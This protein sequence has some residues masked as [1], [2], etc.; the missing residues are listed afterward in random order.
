VGQRRP[1]GKTTLN[2]LEYL[3][4]LVV[5]AVVILLVIHPWAVYFTNGLPDHWDP[6][7]DA[8]HLCWNAHNILHGSV[9]RPVY[10]ANHFYPHAYT[11]AFSEPMW[12]PSFFAAI[13]YGITANPMLTWNATMLFFW[14]LS[15]VTMFALLRELAVSRA[16]AYLGA[17]IFCLMPYRLAYYVEINMSLCFAIPLTYLFLIRWL[18]RRAW[19]DAVLLGLSVWIAATTCLYYTLIM[20][21]PMPFVLIAYLV[22]T[23][24]ILGQGRTYATGATAVVLAALLCA[25]T[26]YPYVVLRAEGKYAR[27]IKQQAHSSIQPLTYLRPAKRSLVH[28]FAAKADP[29]ETV[30]FPG[31]TL[32]ALA[33][34][35]WVRR[36]ITFRPWR[37]APPRVKRR[38]VLAYLRA[39]LWFVFVVLA[40][41]GTYHTHTSSFAAVKDLVVPSINLVFWLSLILLFMPVDRDTAGTAPVLAGL[42]VGAVACFILSFGPTLTLGHMKDTIEVGGGIAARLHDLV[43][44]FS[45]VRVM[46]RFTIMIL[47][48]MIVAGCIALDGFLLKAPRRLRWMWILLFVL[49]LTETYSKPYEFRDCR[50]KLDTPVQTYIRG[51]ENTVSIAQIPYGLRDFDGEAMLATVGRWHY[52]ING[53]C[54]FEPKQHYTLKAYL[55]SDQSAA[56]DWLRQIWPPAYLL[57]DREGVYWWKE[58]KAATFTEDDLADDWALVIQDPRFAL[59]TLKPLDETPP[60]VVRRLRTDVLRRHPRLRFEARAIEVPQG[61]TA[62]VR[63]Q[64]NGHGVAVLALTSELQSF[65]ALVPRDATG[66]LFGEEVALTLQFASPDRVEQADRAGLWAVRNLDFFEQ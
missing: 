51:M 30:V 24:R 4:L 2:A 14:A 13:V 65:E 60:R 11:M 54:G 3:A 9:L 31:L 19:I 63:I 39:A 18:R 58:H 59:Y 64:V 22:R 40:V 17:A 45:I 15:G 27:S 12:P 56:A 66:S 26:M 28:R 46:T 6:P 42:G 50:D 7:T 38:Q 33:C 48:Y 36:R 41:Y 23:P 29:G 52:L 5:L 8:T 16:V 1:A 61:A 57:V 62:Q 37:D 20:L 49:L 21:V 25:A 35:H 43:P 32:F 55:S 34:L 44:I 47:I 10:D 53:W